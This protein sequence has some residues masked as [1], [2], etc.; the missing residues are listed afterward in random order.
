MPVGTG[1]TRAKG[2]SQPWSVFPAPS[3]GSLILDFFSSA[4]ELQLKILGGPGQPEAPPGATLSLSLWGEGAA[5]PVLH[6]SGSVGS[7]DCHIKGPSR[8]LQPSLEFPW[9]PAQQPG[10]GLGWAAAGMG[11]SRGHS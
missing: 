1:V 4:L 10:S 3:R 8:H 9:I 11:I 2:S 5:L 6:A 7:R